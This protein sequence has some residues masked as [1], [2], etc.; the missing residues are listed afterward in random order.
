MIHTLHMLPLTAQRQTNGSKTLGEQI[1]YFHIIGNLQ[2]HIS[3]KG[4]GC[5]LLSAHASSSMNVAL[6]FVGKKV[7]GG[8]G[9]V[10]AAQWMAN[11]KGVGAPSHP[12]PPPLMISAKDAL[13]LFQFPSGRDVEEDSRLS[14]RRGGGGVSIRFYWWSVDG[15]MQVYRCAPVYFQCRILGKSCLVTMYSGSILVLVFC[16]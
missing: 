3:F 15:R 16:I 4:Y 10:P 12:H 2:I 7:C 6:F 14:S 8:W 13:L 9:G 5:G 1:F 11:P